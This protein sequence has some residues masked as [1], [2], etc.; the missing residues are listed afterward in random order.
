[1]TPN[2]PEG[3]RQEYTAGLGLNLSRSARID[4]GY[5]YLHQEKRAGRTTNGGKVYPQE[6]PVSANNGMYDFHAN[7]FNAMLSFRF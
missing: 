6:V 5:M 2:L 4:I 7:I 1:V 3:T